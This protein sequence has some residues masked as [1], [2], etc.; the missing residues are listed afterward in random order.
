MSTIKRILGKSGIE[1][2][3]MGLGCWAIGGPFLL[4]GKPDGW[5]DID[6]A[7]SIHAIHAAIDLGINFFDTADAY[8]TGH[9][10]E[11]LGKALKGMRDKVVIATKGGFVYD[12]EKKELTGEDT[13]PAYFRKA[14]EASLKRL[15]TDY[16]DLYQVHNW[17]VPEE[18]VEPLFNEFD[19]FVAEG[20][21]R[22]YG[23]STGEVQNARYLAKHTSGSSVQHPANIFSYD[24][25]IDAVCEENGLAI[26][27]NGPLA[28]GLLSGKFTKESQLPRDD[29]RGANHEWVGYF[30]DGKPL[31]EMIKKLDA[32][33]EI[34]QSDGRSLVQ[35]A[36]AWLWAKSPRNIP[37]PGFKN[38]A[39]AEEN[40]KAIAY[41]PLTQGQMDQIDGLL[42]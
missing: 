13:S 4:F 9:S 15:G 22:A 34:L 14:L 8:G 2:S 11:V 27:D 42:H 17:V 31:P 21:I 38:I 25:D 12:M 35:G 29:V 39:Q 20:K 6:D 5:G 24:P 40:A 19:R 3:P 1:V 32:I 36:L 41:G 18:N 16:I 37:I 30:K 26:I 33:K 10:E 28:M 23:W 7:E